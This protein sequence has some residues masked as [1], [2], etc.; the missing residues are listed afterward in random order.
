MKKFLS[1]TLAAVMA[2]S[3]VSCGSS[4]DTSVGS[5]SSV[6]SAVENSV[7]NIY[8]LYDYE[9]DEVFY[10]DKMDLDDEL[11]EV[12]TT[13]EFSFLSD[14]YQI[15]AYMAI[16]NESIEAQTPCKCLIYNRGGHYDYTPLDYRSV[17]VICA[18]T[19]RIVV[20]CEI[21]GGNGSEGYDRFGGDELHDVIKLT[22]LC[23]NHFSFVDMDDFCAMGISRGGIATYMSARQDKRVK[24]IAVLSGIC[25]LFSAY[26][27]REEGMKQVLRDCI[28]GSP[29]EMPE[30]YE[31]RSALYWADEINIPVLLIHSKGDSKVPFAQVEKMYEKLKDHTDCTFIVHD[32]DLH[33]LHEEDIPK[34]VEW[35]QK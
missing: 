32:D 25:D 22:D 31:K 19:K 15:K 28:G 5:E 12:C 7:R 17:S 8:D 1:I 24:K 33:D 20:A 26:E 11:A 18:C 6:P 4:G 23:E 9:N 34:I 21:R 27:E 3:L 16:P 2:L 13:Y 35:L 30:E 10:V 29:E 14:G